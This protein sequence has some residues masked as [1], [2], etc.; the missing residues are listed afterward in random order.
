[1]LEAQVKEDLYTPVRHDVML[2]LMLPAAVQKCSCYAADLTQT[3]RGLSSGRW[4]A[5]ALMQVAEGKVLNRHGCGLHS[6]ACACIAHL[7]GLLRGRQGWRLKPLGGAYCCAVQE[8]LIA[9]GCL[10]RRSTAT[11]GSPA[12]PQVTICRQGHTCSASVRSI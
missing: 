8:R 9:D 10:A 6:L 5:A 4:T 12:M 2:T 7:A 3:L 11:T 1:M